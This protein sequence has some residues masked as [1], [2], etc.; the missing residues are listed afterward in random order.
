MGLRFLKDC[1]EAIKNLLVFLAPNIIF[2]GQ[3]EKDIGLHLLNIHAMTGNCSAS[4]FCNNRKFAFSNE[5]SITSSDLRSLLYFVLI[6]CRILQPFP[7]RKGMPVNSVSENPRFLRCRF[8][9]A[10]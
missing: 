9:N 8:R 7:N 5:Q 2:I 3:L 6:Y 10:I 4:G 1:L